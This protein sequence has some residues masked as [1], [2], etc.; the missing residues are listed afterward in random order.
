M[1]L[2]T[3]IMFFMVRDQGFTF[4]KRKSPWPGTAWV[5]ATWEVNE[6]PGITVFK[7]CEK[8]DQR[9]RRLN[10]KWQIQPA[11]TEAFRDRLRE[12]P[13]DNEREK[14]FWRVDMVGKMMKGQGFNSR[15]ELLESLSAA[16][17]LSDHLY[18]DLNRNECG[19]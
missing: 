12:M 11:Y 4:S 19:A 1:S 10:S 5:S 13:G 17:W 14:L 18:N 7:L 6:I 2:N 3:D 16:W 15:K 9:G 8:F